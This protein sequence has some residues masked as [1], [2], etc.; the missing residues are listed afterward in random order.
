[1]LMK[2][3]RCRL[4]QRLHRVYVASYNEVPGVRGGAV[5]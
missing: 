4:V 1:M 5:G 2:A 3:S